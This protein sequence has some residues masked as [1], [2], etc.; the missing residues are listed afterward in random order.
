MVTRS[1]YVI[2]FDAKISG[3]L[4]KGESP[5]KK[6][7]LRQLSYLPHLTSTIDFVC[8]R[9]AVSKA[10]FNILGREWKWTF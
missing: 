1:F 4:G 8:H 9:E 7:D 6:R 3:M 10:R 5:G 2:E